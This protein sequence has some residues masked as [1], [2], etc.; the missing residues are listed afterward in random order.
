MHPEQPLRIVVT[1]ASSGI[2]NA[3]ASALA[4][5][6]HIVLGLAR[7]FPT[8]VT[9]FVNQSASSRQDIACDVSQWDQVTSIANALKQNWPAID[10]LVCCA[11]VQGEICP[12]FD[13]DPQQWLATVQTNLAGTYFPIRAFAPLLKQTN[14]RAKIL[15]FSGGGA[16]RARP[17]FSSYAASKTGV[18][19]LV[20]TIASEND[21]LPLDINA[22]APGAVPTFM[23]DSIIAA[24]PELA[25]AQEY[26]SA[27]ALKESG[28]DPMKRALDLVDW[29]I[30]PASDGVTGRLLSANWDPWKTLTSANLKGTE[31]YK[32]RRVLP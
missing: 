3:V 10:A 31:I 26:Q 19:R 32:L 9:D 15:C 6:G 8:T 27:L 12:A 5:N 25:G 16:S 30:S 11:A 28:S 24:G 2:G 21:G 20:E 17:N 13:S 29:L 4:T 1:G 7:R 22:I 18:V 23:T 14:R